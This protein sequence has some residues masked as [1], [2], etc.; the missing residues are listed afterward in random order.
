MRIK[1]DQPWPPEREAHFGKFL[2]EVSE[3]IAERAAQNPTPEPEPDPEPWVDKPGTLIAAEKDLWRWEMCQ[4]LSRVLC[5]DM[6]KCQDGRCRRTKR[7]RKL[8]EIAAGIETARATL[9]AEQAKWQPPP[10]P[11]VPRRRRKKG[12]AGA[13]P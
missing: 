10:L 2:R 1:R 7:C 4:K 11:P 8:E 9:A 5:Q 3:R 13:R 12:R 6:A